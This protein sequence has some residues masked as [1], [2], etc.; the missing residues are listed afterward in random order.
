MPS[1]RR[2]ITV[3]NRRRKKTQESPLQ[4]IYLQTSY[5]RNIEKIDS[6]IR[7]IPDHTFGKVYSTQ[8]VSHSQTMEQIPSPN[9]S[10]TMES[11]IFISSMQKTRKN[12][13]MKRKENNRKLS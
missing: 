8:I 3:T 4:F 10:T 13:S 2:R 11:E 5:E 9:A 1:K 12:K 7:T 6:D